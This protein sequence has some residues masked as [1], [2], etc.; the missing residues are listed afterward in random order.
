MCVHA[1]A[2]AY[3]RLRACIRALWCV[4]AWASVFVETGGN[5]KFGDGTVRVRGM[6]WGV[7]TQIHVISLVLNC[8]SQ[9]VVC[10]AILTTPRQSGENISKAR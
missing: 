4:P 7:R 3:V 8:L 2:C 1:P 5:E 6:G 9:H 10:A